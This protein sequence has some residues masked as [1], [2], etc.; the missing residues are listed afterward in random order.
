MRLLHPCGVTVN[1][2]TVIEGILGLWAC[3]AIAVFKCTSNYDV[4]IGWGG[5]AAQFQRVP[6]QLGLFPMPQKSAERFRSGRDDVNAQERSTNPGLSVEEE[7][8]AH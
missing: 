5:L 8:K 3:P 4:R 1:P 2:T 6:K 7:D